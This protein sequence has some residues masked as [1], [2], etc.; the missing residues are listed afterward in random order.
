MTQCKAFIKGNKFEISDSQKY[1]MAGNGVVVNV[2]EE[3]IK[4]FIK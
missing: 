2:V 4:Q 3:L 1:K